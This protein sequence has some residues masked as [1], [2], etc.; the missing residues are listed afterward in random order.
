MTN[1]YYLSYVSNC[2]INGFS[3]YPAI[4][5]NIFTI[6]AIEKTTTLSNKTLKTLLLSL[7]ASDLGVGLVVQPL[8]IACLAMEMEHITENNLNYNNIYK[9]F[10]L[11]AN[12]FGFASFFCVTALSADRFLSVHFNLRYRELVTHRRVVGVVISIW[13]ISAFLS[14]IRIFISKKIMYLIFTS[15]DLLGANVAS[16]YGMLLLAGDINLDMFRPEMSEMKRYNELLD[17]LN[18]KQMVT[19]ATR[20]TKTSKTLINH[21]ITNAPKRITYNEVLPRPLPTTTPR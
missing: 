12:T 16:W 13:V 3:S 15:E 8:Y 17:S 18:L 21:I 4:M 5:L 10:L 7:A 6:Y 11:S 14:L 9:A 1:T 19:K 20:I 2:V